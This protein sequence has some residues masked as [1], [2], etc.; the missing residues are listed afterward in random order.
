[1][2]SFFKVFVFCFS[3]TFIC[4]A[5]YAAKGPIYLNVDVSAGQWKAARLKKLPKGAVVSVKVESS[6][7]ILVGLFDST[8]RGK[9]DVSRPL[10][11]GR[12]GKK[13]SFSITVEKTGDHYLLLDNRRGSETRAVKVILRAA[14]SAVDQLEAANQMMHLFE[15][16]LGRIFIFEPFPIG[17]KSC[18][19]PRAFLDSPGVTLCAEYMHHL[20]DILENRERTQDILSFSLF[21]ETGRVLLTK[22]DH[23]FADTVETVD[24]LAAVLMVMVKQQ[25]KAIGAAEHIVKNPSQSGIM[26]KLF[27]DDN[28]PLTVKRAG[29][30]LIR[31][32]DPKLPLK[33]Q[34][35]LV[36]HM[37]TELLKKLKARPTKWTDASLV[38]RELAIR[39]KKTL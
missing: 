18:G 29:K 13:L 21:H 6:G 14:R 5:V 35:F 2:G 7:D 19:V 26:E 3:F 17:I 38:E 22:W 34:A 16:Q 31:V 24:E 28:H 8:S 32:K 23:P 27:P 25:N 37:Q 10:F 9:P 20:Y 33:W 12:V 4:P 1:M 36:P 30:V 11:A 15:L 39:Q